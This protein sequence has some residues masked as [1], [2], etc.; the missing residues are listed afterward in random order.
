MWIAVA[1]LFFSHSATSLEA[2]VAKTDITA[3]IGA[4]LNGYGARMG[5]SSTAVHDPLWC[6]ALYLETEDTRLFL[7]SVDLVAV[8]PELRKRV[9]ELV[10]DLIPSENIILT[11]THTHNGHGGMVRSIPLRFV[12]GRF[13]PELLES[14]AQ[15]I[16]DAMRVAYTSRRRAAIGYAVG[17]HQGLSVNR[18]YA[19]GPNDTQIMVVLV[20]DADG[21]PLSVVTQFTAHP[22]SIGD[23][24]LYEISADYPGYY[25]QEIESLFGPSCVAL[26]LNGALGNQTIGNPENKSGWAR[27]ESVGR[28]LAKKVH[29]IA[30]KITFADITIR[31]SYKYAR[32]PLTTAELLQP[33]EVLLQSLEINDFLLSFFP[34]EPCVELGLHL[35]ERA[36][37]RGYAAHA[38]IGLSNDY[39]M[40]FVPRHLYADMTYESVMTFF[41]PGI[42]D[43]FYE[44]FES[45]MTR[46][47]PLSQGNATEVKAH[48]EQHEWG[49]LATVSGSPYDIGITLGQRFGDSI[50]TLYSERVL[51]PVKNR[52]WLPQEGMWSALPGFIETTAFAL[53]LLGMGSRNLLKGLSVDLLREMEGMAEGAGISFDGFWLLQNAVLYGAVQ[54]KNALL[55]A[56]L[57]TMF[58]VAGDSGGSETILV[59]RNLDWGLPEQ[60][61][62]TRITPREGK[63][64]LAAG[65][66]W[67][68]GLFT[69]INEAGLVVCMERINE[70]LESFPEKSPVEFVLRDII[71]TCTTVEES[72]AQL[73]SLTYLEGIHVL[74]A[75]LGKSKPVAAVVELSATP[76]VRFMENNLLLG[77]S[78]ENA[79]ASP[80]TQ[81]RYTQLRSYLTS[82]V[83]PT[84]DDV[85]AFMSG[86]GLPAEDDPGRIWN[87]RTRHCA[88]LLPAAPAM[89]IT[90]TGNDGVALK[91]TLVQFPG[92]NE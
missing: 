12:S 51:T 32:L 84:A 50:K 75:G 59:G 83:K 77:V 47:T 54:D 92:E 42:E 22:T 3:P 65:F 74:V 18:R 70:E 46:P 88:V 89:K 62:V 17:E 30:Q 71:R 56:P 7:V 38:S 78:P 64:Y 23:E 43:W 52:E 20:E 21:N 27:T 31:F 35:R 14:T 60:P 87:T 19:G 4:P 86:N 48:F 80:S 1:V 90:F 34:G 55:N 5:R 13:M 44:Q 29:E 24:S 82:L 25:Y 26:F 68:M 39:I 45:L 8:N 67:N 61:V 9:A 15:G 58:A 91:P 63:A 28:L 16:A 2:G 79:K 85:L 37:S 36:K 73:K 10:S 72:I 6:R 57:C 49:T 11:A 76:T 40:Y 69:A 33:K 81:R 53:P 41:G 66:T